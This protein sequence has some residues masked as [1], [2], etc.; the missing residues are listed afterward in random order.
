MEHIRN[1]C[2]LNQS[3]LPDTMTLGY[4]PAIFRE[5]ACLVESFL[6]EREMDEV[7]ILDFLGLDITIQRAGFV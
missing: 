7:E 5:D 4:M 3:A 1:L 2:G 6:V